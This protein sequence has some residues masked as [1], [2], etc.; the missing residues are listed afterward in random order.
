MHLDI[1]YV[2]HLIR[3]INRYRRGCICVCLTCKE[4]EN[5]NG[6]HSDSIEEPWMLK[7]LHG[8]IDAIVSFHRKLNGIMG[9]LRLCL[10]SPSIHYLRGQLFV[11]L[12][13]TMDV[14]ECAHSIP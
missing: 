12:S 9:K 13:E 2:Q 11:V 6:F 7:D 4:I 8:L 3:A 5:S 14:I 10:K 1:L